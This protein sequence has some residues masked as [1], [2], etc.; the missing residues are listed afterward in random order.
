VYDIAQIMADPHV[1]ARE[2]VVEYPDDEMGQIPMHGI[3]PKLGVTPG[4]VR[5]PAPKLGEH[6]A[7]LLS[8]LGVSAQDL[9]RLES[10]QVIY[11][12]PQRKKAR[13]AGAGT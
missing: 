8:A 10:S 3:A 4:A 11:S 9:Q 5:L 13:T 7:E 12:G 6:N 1:R 2:M